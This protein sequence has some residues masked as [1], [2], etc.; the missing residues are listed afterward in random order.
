M[1]DQDTNTVN[2][3]IGC[4]LPCRTC[5]NGNTSACLSCYNDPAI[6]LNNLLFPTNSQCVSSC[7][8]GYYDS[9]SLTCLACASTCLTCNLVSTNCTSCN[10]SSANPAL[11]ISNNV[12]SCLSACPLYFY[13]SNT[14]TPPQC[15]VCD[16]NTYH[17]STCS[18][19]DSCTTCLANF[20]FYQNT[21]IPNCPS[22]FT[23]ANLGTW[24]CDP[25][26]TQCATCMGVISNCTSCAST[27]A[28]YN[29]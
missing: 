11:N 10:T 9:G 2:F 19:I 3:T 1:I 4:V 17:C 7:P 20:F 22:N 28:F 13:L 16:N 8:S 15:V 21:C 18:A 25:C 27:S 26:S 5:S 29:G 14:A 6:S 12:G 23:V 24:T